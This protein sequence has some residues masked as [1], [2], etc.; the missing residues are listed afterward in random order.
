MKGEGAALRFVHNLR[1]VFDQH[2]RSSLLIRDPEHMI[3]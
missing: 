2:S 3:R 1:K